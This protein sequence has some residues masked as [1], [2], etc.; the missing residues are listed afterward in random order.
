MMDYDFHQ[1]SPHDLEI[2]ARDLLQAEWRVNLESF[3]S[4]RDQGIDLRYV[5]VQNTTIV[6]CKHY[7]RTGLSGLLRDLNKEAAKVRQLKPTR[8]VLVTSI[9]LSPADKSKIIDIIGSDV[10]ASGDILGHAELNGLLS[11]HSDVEGRH[12]KLW[13]A[14]R[15]V[16]DRV[17]HNAAVTQSEF[18]VQQVY[19]EARRYVQSDAYPRALKMLRDARVVII[20]GPPGVG[21]TTLA[22]LLLY[23]HLENGYQ[24]VVIQRDIEEGQKLFQRGQRQVFYFDDFMGATFLGDVGGA[25]KE[26]DAR[27]LLEFVAMVR[28]TPTARLVLTTREHLYSQGINRSERLRNSDLDDLRVFLRMPDYS[29]VQRA[30]ILY[31]HLYFS[32]LPSEYQ[33]KLL[34]HGFYLRIIKHNKFNPRIIEW[35]SSY[36]RVR[37]VPVGK[38]LT[39]V[40]SLLIDPAEIWRHAYEQEISEAA[41][42]LL[43]A[44]FS[45]GGK[46]SA[47]VLKSSF[48]DLHGERART[49]GFSTR[50]EDFRSAFREVAGA[51]LKPM[52]FGDGV[53]VVDPSVL[54]L[55]N[56][57]VRES[58]ENAV[59]I[60]AG[61]AISDQIE[62]IW[63]FAN[64]ESG[65]SVLAALVSSIER[66]E[67]P[68]E[69]CMLADRRVKL[70][71]GAISY[72][73]STFQRRMIVIVEM[74]ERMNSV[75]FQPLVQSL[76]KRMVREW[77]AT[78]INT[79]DTCALLRVLC[80]SDQKDAAGFQ[81]S[82]AQRLIAEANNECDS[83][84]FRMIVET[85]H[86]CD[87]LGGAVEALRA[88]FN[89]YRE[90]LFSGELSE[91]RA[92]EQYDGLIQDLEVLKLM[93][94]VEVDDLVKRVM[95][96]KFEFEENLEGH[97]E[98][99]WREHWQNDRDE[100]RD[101]LDMFG[102][103]GTDR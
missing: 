95:E 39:F 41:R 74:V 21:K 30:K 81:F 46:A 22:N 73:G 6:Q 71:G 78:Y 35:L 20:A 18:K 70:E 55:L 49:Y 86:A 65:G 67:K 60:V 64:A 69:R 77:H 38:Y 29:V 91:C 68:L 19:N 3:K 61:A 92:T 75:G 10:L 36:R 5:Q 66:L 76:F 13:L 40:E 83:I 34:E 33:D 59:D 89:S 100:D 54:D 8:Y 25:G 26:S 9:P 84:E 27:A 23:E 12:F 44:I 50:P 11:Q 16:L 45:L 52:A 58:P 97:L 101:V 2:L 94:N 72:Q 53:E 51:F 87:L 93:L 48:T 43:L 98:D 90:N 31:N 47:R 42:S 99:D 57:V 28:S 32:D 4:G 63:Q 79:P 102:S 82:I 88:A 17:L 7:I 14:S 24:A 85:L 37:N 56:M 80:R 62:R 1:L 96:G 15:A 103:L